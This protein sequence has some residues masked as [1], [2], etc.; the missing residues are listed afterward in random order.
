M[1]I[2]VVA[3]SIALVQT[4]GGLLPKRQLQERFDQFMR[5]QWT[6][7][8]ITGRDCSD[9]ACQSQYRRRRTQTDTIDRRAERAEAL[10]Y[11]GEFSSGRHALE[12]APLAFGNEETRLA[13]TDERRRPPMLRAPLSEDLLSFQPESS[14]HL[15]QVLLLK[16]LKCAK[17][18]AAGGPSG[19]TAEHLRPVL[20][21]SRDA[22]RF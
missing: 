10:I 7:L 18:G 12:G 6:Q 22:E 8:L 13:W 19:M 2:V 5:G 3:A 4:C 21:S 14:L 17:R 20:E 9:R 15:S 1:E 16:N 11:L